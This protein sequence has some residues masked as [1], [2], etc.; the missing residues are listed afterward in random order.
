MVVDIFYNSQQISRN[1]FSAAIKTITLL[2][3]EQENGFLIFRNAV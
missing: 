3:N 1:P 2:E